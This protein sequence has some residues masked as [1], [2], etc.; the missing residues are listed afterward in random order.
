MS[1]VN[2]SEDTLSPAGLLS[3]ADA[4]ALSSDSVQTTDLASE[5][6]TSGEAAALQTT[7]TTVAGETPAA[8]GAGSE[9]GASDEFE[10]FDLS[11]IEIIESKVFA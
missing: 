7:E 11:D 1:S 2:E 6:T 9:T 10:D 3:D 5:T 4:G 8:T